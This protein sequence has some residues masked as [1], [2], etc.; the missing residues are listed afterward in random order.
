MDL[1]LGG[2]GG[3]G[4]GCSLTSALTL[5]IYIS[6]ICVLCCNINFH[7]QQITFIDKILLQK[8]KHNLRNMLLSAVCKKNLK[9]L[10][11][12]YKVISKYNLQRNVQFHTK[13]LSSC[14]TKEYLCRN[15]VAIQPCRSVESAAKETI[16]YNFGSFLGS[17]R[18]NITRYMAQAM[19]VK[20][21][22]E[23]CA[24]HITYIDFFKACQMPDTFQSWFYVLH[25]HMWMVLIRLRSEGKY[26]KNLS[27]YM[28]E[29]MWKDLQE[30]IKLLGV[31][32]TSEKK[33]TMEEYAQQFFGLIVAYDEGLLGHDRVL[34][35]ALWRNLFYNKENTD[36]ESLALM[37]GYVRKQIQYL[38]QQ[39]SETIL[40]T[41]EI[42]WLPL[43]EE[44]ITSSKVKF[45]DPG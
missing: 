9:C 5:V 36:A 37:V 15:N 19:A 20:K 34:A 14:Y 35:S 16:S 4:G 17:L 44:E 39:D 45:P 43:H 10:T 7:V 1:E 29:L 11:S 42:K 12:G 6:F 41:G 3:G 40:L 2:G 8:Y 27:Y 22:Y 24:H 30:R 13:I 38:E 26:G 18:T 32:D 31:E 25:L 28:V 23:C 33:E 21:L